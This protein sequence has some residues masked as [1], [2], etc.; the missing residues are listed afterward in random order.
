MKFGKKSN[1]WDSLDSF[2]IVVSM[3]FLFVIVGVVLKG[4][5][6]EGATQGFFNTTEHE[7][8]K[9]FSENVGSK[10]D[11][12]APFLFFALMIASLIF[13]FKIPSNS[14]F[15]V[16]SF[17][18]VPFIGL[19]IM[20]LGEITY[21]FITDSAVTTVTSSMPITLFFFQGN[22]PLILGIIYILL[23]YIALYAGKDE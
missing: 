1:V 21:A 2:I 13:A 10:F 3:V 6:T 22:N 16:V 8:V 20:I 14:V 12:V 11:W 17:F 15:F 19:M 23:T 7:S 4:F 9:D 5:Y 18:V